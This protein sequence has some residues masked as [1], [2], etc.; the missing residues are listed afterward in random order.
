MKDVRLVVDR[1]ARALA[2]AVDKEKDEGLL[3]RVRDEL[4]RLA[5]VVRESPELRRVLASPVVSPEAKSRVVLAIA[6][7]MQV[8]PITRRFLEVVGRHERLVLLPEIAAA[9]GREVD[10]REGIR[11]VELRS[12]APLADDVRSRVEEALRAAAGGRIRL[13]EH[14]DEELLGGL[15]ARIGGT[16][17]DGSLKT[18]LERLRARLR[19]ESA[20]GLAG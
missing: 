7:R 2:G 17:I 10:R 8:A 15:V 16:V 4:V 19:S 3:P 13:A 5:G 9:V 1:Y 12:A 6:D 18:R 11:E 20:A 14:V